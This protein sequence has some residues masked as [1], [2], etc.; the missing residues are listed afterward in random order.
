RGP[1]PATLPSAVAG[2]VRAAEQPASVL[3]VLIAGLVVW[4]S[5]AIRASALLMAFKLVQ[6]AI[7]LQ[8]PALG[9]PFNDR[10]MMLGLSMALLP[11]AL[12]ASW[13]LYRWAEGWTA[14]RRAA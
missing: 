14:G 4:K 11:A 12:L 1:A 9:E 3:A 13:A 2:W 7:N 10:A 5:E 6:W 8:W